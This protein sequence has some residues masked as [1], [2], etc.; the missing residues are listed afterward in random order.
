MPIVC[1]HCYDLGN[2]DLIM[3][4]GRLC[5]K[6][7][8]HMVRAEGGEATP[9]NLETEEAAEV[10]E[11]EEVEAEADEDEQEEATEDATDL[12]EMTKNDL[13]DLAKELQVAG[14]WK[15]KKDKLIVAIEKA[16]VEGKE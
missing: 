13:R 9:K 4:V 7:G 8:N 3:D 10:A 6:C 14:A 16:W 2:P 15:M 1:P 12:N 11:I 5:P